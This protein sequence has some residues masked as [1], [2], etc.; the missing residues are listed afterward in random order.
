MSTNQQS[1]A[2]RANGLSK[3]HLIY[4]RPENRLKQMVIPRLQR[5]LRLPIY[6]YYRE[7]WAL[8]DI[9]VD[10]Y[11]GE[12]LGIIGRNG[13]GKSTLLQLLCGTL[14]PTTGS[15]STKGRIAALLELGSGF[16]SEFTGRENVYLNGTV[17]G[18]SRGEIDNRF[19]AIEQFADIG[20]FIDQPVKT[21]S[22]GMLVRLA[23]AV[24]AN[25]DADILVIDEALA[26]GDAIFTQKCMRFLRSFKES[27][28]LIF[29]SHDTHSVMSLCDRALWLDKGR[30]RMLGVAKEVAEA[31]MEYSLQEIYGESV[32]LASLI[33]RSQT[34]PAPADLIDTKG[35]QP[36]SFAQ[37][38]GQAAEVGEITLFDNLDSSNGWQTGSARITSVQLRAEGRA[39]Q[40]ALRGGDSVTLSVEVE[41]LTSLSSPIVGFLVRDRLGQTLFAENTFDQTSE[42]ESAIAG[43][44]LTAAF[45]FLLPILPSG[46]Y[47]VTV[48]IAEGTP[49]SNVQHHWIHDA[50]LFNVVTTKPWLGLMGIPFRSISLTRS[51]N[52]VGGHD[53]QKLTR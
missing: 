32:A 30:M 49:S 21:Y 22:S 8:Q 34:S 36:L 12:T 47:S 26:V 14:C 7:F 20:D 46:S 3:C 23:F 33:P 25:V 11:R 16:N 13:A 40:A 50:I 48:A 35:S 17:L 37:P 41:L 43:E 6:Q 10:I 24:I 29:V 19:S 51:T 4:E 18:L 53:A 15:I 5:L 2:V 39:T 45:E 9:S 28:T 27:N 31:Y 42:F 1:I 44:T 52:S 38:Q